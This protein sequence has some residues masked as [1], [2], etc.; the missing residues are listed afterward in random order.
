[1]QQVS[2]HVAKT[3]LSALVAKAAEGDPFIIA[4]A[5][6]PLV[7]V[8]PY[9]KEKASKRTGFLKGTFHIPDDFNTMGEKEI[10]EMFEC[11][12]NEDSY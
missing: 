9:E 8:T 6:V 7:I 4:R 5:G 2:I 11:D 10:V 1:M 3:N 12:V